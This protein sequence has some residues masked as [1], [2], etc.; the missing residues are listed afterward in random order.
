MPRPFVNRKIGFTPDFFSFKPAGIPA[1]KLDRIELSLDELEALRLAD[2]EGLYQDEA[3][4]LMEV[5]RQT[6]GNILQSAH[7]KVAETLI[8]GA[9]LN[10]D[11]GPV[12]KMRDRN[13][14]CCGCGHQWKVPFGETRPE[15]CPSCAD[16]DF[17]RSEKDFE[18][19]T[20]E[21]RKRRQYRGRSSD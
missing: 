4:R 1:K 8:Y 12:D 7:R 19:S 6:F 13:Y 20:Q 2:L 15:K 11:G 14:K 3:A 5:S 10:I 17:I 16:Q 18:D 21:D 9:S